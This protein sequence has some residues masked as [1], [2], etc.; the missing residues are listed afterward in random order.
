MVRFGTGLGQGANPQCGRT[1]TPLRKIAARRTDLPEHGHGEPLGE[2]VHDQG[3]QGVQ[4]GQ[5]VGQ[6]HP[7]DLLPQLEEQDPCIYG[8]GGAM[9]ETMTDEGQRAK[10]AAG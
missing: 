9:R 6:V 7:A 1:S 10:A 8:W 3:P 2:H 5:L 4:A